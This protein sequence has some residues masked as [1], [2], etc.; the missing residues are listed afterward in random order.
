MKTW[1]TGKIGELFDAFEL[2]ENRAE[3]EKFFRDLCTISELEEFSKRW[4]VAKMLHQKKSI[5]EISAHT[6]LS[7]TTV[8]RVGQ[9][10]KNLGDGGYDLVLERMEENL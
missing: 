5:R 7:T 10:K 1:K 9:W 2:L 3:R 6:G 8:S 4:E